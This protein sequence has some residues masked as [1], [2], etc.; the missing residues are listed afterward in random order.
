MIVVQVRRIDVYDG[1]V[2]SPLVPSAVE[3]GCPCCG[4]PVKEVELEWEV[5]GFPVIVEQVC[6]ACDWAQGW[7]HVHQW[8][9]TPDT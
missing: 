4:A 1:K 3:A 8:V 6:S 7:D 5:S 2:P 9:S